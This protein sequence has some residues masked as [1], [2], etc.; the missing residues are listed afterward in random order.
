MNTIG[1]T[2]VYIMIDICVHSYWHT[3]TIGLA[4]V[5][6]RIDKCAH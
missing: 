1:L 3:C 4:H 2:H 6:V 5:Y